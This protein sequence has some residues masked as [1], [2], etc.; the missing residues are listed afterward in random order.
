ME[1]VS[2]L[3]AALGDPVGWIR[4][5]A[6]RAAQELAP[7]RAGGL[8]AEHAGALRRPLAVDEASTLA[9]A[10]A[11]TRENPLPLTAE[12]LQVPQD[13]LREA[14]AGN[15]ADWF[16]FLRASV[17]SAGLRGPVGVIGPL[18]AA[19][20]GLSYPPAALRPGRSAAHR[21]QAAKSALDRWSRMHADPAAAAGA[22]EAVRTML[23]R[24]D[25]AAAADALIAVALTDPHEWTRVVA[26]KAASE[27]GLDAA[28]P[29][30]RKLAGDDGPHPDADAV[31]AIARDDRRE[32]ID[33]LTPEGLSMF[34]TAE[35]L[36]DFADPATGAAVAA[37]AIGW[38]GD[39][40]ARVVRVAGRMSASAALPAL[41]WS[42]RHLPSPRE[43]ARAAEVLHRIV[44]LDGALDAPFHHIH[45]IEFPHGHLDWLLDLVAR[46]RTQT[47][48]D[49]DPGVAI[50]ILRE[51]I[52]ALPD[53]VG[54]VGQAYSTARTAHLAMLFGSHVPTIRHLFGDRP[55]PKARLER[56][57]KIDFPEQCSVDAEV[58]LTVQL[59]AVAGPAVGPVAVPFDEGEAEVELLVVVQAPGFSVRE[60]VKAMTVP[61]DGSSETVAF[62]LRPRAAG[63]QV[64]DVKFM[65]GTATIGQSCVATRVIERTETTPESAGTAA[66]TMLEPIDAEALE[67]AGVAEA[68]FLVQTADN[69]RLDWTLVRPTGPREFLGQSSGAFEPA[70]VAAWQVEQ[71]RLIREML[72]PEPTPEDLDALRA[73]LAAT[74][75]EL[76]AQIAP[77]GLES[78]L[79]GLN[80]NALVV[81]DCD[82]DWIPWELLASRPEGTLWGE[83][84]VLV[85]SPVASR[86]PHAT[87]ATPT[88]VTTALDRAL[89]VVGDE[90]D[91][92]GRVG[93]LTF[94]RMEA[95]AAP[96][97]IKAS[98]AEL[99]RD[100][101]GKDIVHFVCHGRQ[102]P[103]YHLSYREGV[104]GRLLP[105][106]VHALGVK[107]GAVVFAN[108]CSS[109]ASDLL[110]SDFQS[111]GR[112]FYYAGARPFIGT[113]GP[114][115][116]REAVEF[117]G[118][119]YEHFA[120]AGLPAGHALRMARQDAARRFK[121]PVWLFYCLYGSPSV[122]RRWS[123][124]PRA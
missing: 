80:E 24:E 25:T 124:A 75:N 4:I 49:G 104:A 73:Q 110:L 2:A 30:L 35:A 98:W 18:I 59:R 119:F 28:T 32:S 3:K 1:P 8:L 17:T 87:I 5:G 43:R 100:V 15:R 39:A 90:I 22:F 109:G 70:R 38:D 50:P 86:P 84:F 45:R 34:L 66:V 68:T 93:Q 102:Q 11:H 54:T 99:Q 105:R 106:Q 19:W 74:G 85:R 26:R 107:W 40:R 29:L 83:R 116:T 64:I 55:L 88:T 7:T 111:F 65:H 71:S 120:I 69:G 63:E 115:P 23:E 36:E 62:A 67:L 48:W 16:E 27:L 42:A 41:V 76:Y 108:A 37:A 114:V 78:V 113:L 20:N 72:E 44:A 121:R 91:R 21:A 33:G 89:L 97:L 96:P 6:I 53:M 112:E 117:A 51:A 12:L 118:L 92:P 101:A 58:T 82:A 122:V 13:R 57:P 46:N 61:R 14:L 31:W 9:I 47:S 10:M 79:D 77:K 56:E 52:E 95:R 81:F 123:M 94:G 60:P 103:S